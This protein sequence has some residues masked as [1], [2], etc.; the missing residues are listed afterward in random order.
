MAVCLVAAQPFDCT[1]H[2][3][4]SGSAEVAFNKANKLARNSQYGA[5]RQELLEILETTD[6][7]IAKIKA[8]II[9]SDIYFM[10]GDSEKTLYYTNLALSIPAVRDSANLLFR[11]NNIVA[12]VYLAKNQIEQ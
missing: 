5:A 3:A 7:D 6:D 1:A 12:W 4:D 10:T 8:C 11:I 2:T 9:L